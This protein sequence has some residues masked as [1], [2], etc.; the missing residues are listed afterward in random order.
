M[1]HRF[2]DSITGTRSLGPELMNTIIKTSLFALLLTCTLSSA[3]AAAQGARG[4]RRPPPPGEA[5]REGARR[6]PGERHHRRQLRRLAHALAPTQAQ[7]EFV[8]NELQ[9]ARPEMESARTR[10]RE[11]VQRAR[12]ARRQGQPVP[13]ETRAGLRALREELRTNLAPHA[14]RIV[15]QLTPEQRATLEE[16]AA[17]HGRKLDEQRLERGATRLMLALERRQHRHDA[18]PAPRG[19]QTR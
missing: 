18:P 16:R 7:R 12:E 11:L 6:E 1:L 9:A 2:T 5:P 13:A 19:P 4:L 17:R 14:R 3:P 15:S 8:R 10:G